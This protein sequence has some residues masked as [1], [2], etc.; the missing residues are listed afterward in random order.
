MIP[1]TSIDGTDITGATIDGTDVQEIT[2]DGDVVFTSGFS[3][4]D[5]FDT[6]TLSDYTI[7]E[8]NLG[9][10]KNFTISGSELI[11]PDN[12]GYFFV[13]Y[14]VSSEGLTDFFVEQVT[15]VYPDNDWSGVGFLVD[16]STIV[17]GDIR[18]QL[19]EAAIG[20]DSFPTPLVYASDYDDVN[21]VSHTDFAT[22]FTVRIEYDSSTD[23]ATLFVNGVEKVS[24]NFTLSGTVTDCGMVIAGNDPGLHL[25]SFEIGSL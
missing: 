10:S 1:P 24:I 20:F 4:F 14:D 23:T 8:T 3:Y 7:H 19:N 11:Q 6:N 9:V 16:G 15:N 12:N 13:Y 22:P 18:I 25:E 5:D 21:T 17:S 2:V